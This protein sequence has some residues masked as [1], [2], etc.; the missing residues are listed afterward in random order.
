MAWIIEILDQLERQRM[1]LRQ[2]FDQRS[3]AAR[4]SFDQRRGG[5]AMGL[6]L[7]VG[8]QPI[9]TIG[10]AFGALKARA[11]GRNEPSRQRGRA[12][13][14]LIALNH[15]RIDAGLVSGQSCAKPRSA[16]AND[17][18]GNVRAP[19]CNRIELDCAHGVA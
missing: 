16:G 7:D 9:W 15:D 19:F 13:R 11:G 3:G 14:D 2:P 10:N 1:A 6:A 18:E 5:F 12:A 17:Q 8:S 4:D